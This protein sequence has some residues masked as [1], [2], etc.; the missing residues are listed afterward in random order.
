MKHAVILC[1]ATRMNG[2]NLFRELEGGLIWKMITGRWTGNIPKVFGGFF[3]SFIKKDWFMKDTKLCIF[4]RDV[5]R[6]F[7]ILK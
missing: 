1:F 4:A 6:H 7:L 3:P 5:K 2:K